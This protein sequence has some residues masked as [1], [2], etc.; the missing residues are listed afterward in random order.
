MFFTSETT[1]FS[2]SLRNLFAQLLL[3]VSMINIKITVYQLIKT[4]FGYFFTT[5]FICVVVP[6]LCLIQKRKTFFEFKHTVGLDLTK[7]ASQ[8]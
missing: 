3:I 5:Q 2:F 6:Q 4:F 8:K 7:E 1:H